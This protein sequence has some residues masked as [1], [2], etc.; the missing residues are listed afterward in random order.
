M[1]SYTAHTLT[2]KTLGPPPLGAPALT[3]EVRYGT[4]E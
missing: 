4:A 2:N 3:E 1:Q